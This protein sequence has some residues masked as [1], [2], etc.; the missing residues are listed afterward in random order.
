MSIKRTVSFPSFDRLYN[1]HIWAFILLQNLRKKL[2][3]QV[4]HDLGEILDEFTSDMQHMERNGDDNE[5]YTSQPGL[6]FMFD[7][8]PRKCT[9]N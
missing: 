3:E 7:V 4:I 5:N 1:D 9:N 8:F 6:V 2:M